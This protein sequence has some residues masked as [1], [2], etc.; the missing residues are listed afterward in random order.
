MH[1]SFNLYTIGHVGVNL[2]VAWLFVGVS[3]LDYRRFK[4]IF[5]N[6]YASKVSLTLKN[7]FI[8]FTCVIYE[9]GSSILVGLKTDQEDY[10]QQN[11]TSQRFCKIT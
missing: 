6:F 3:K 11:N 8:K 10:F 2:K 1:K 4:V 9:K 7:R 5:V